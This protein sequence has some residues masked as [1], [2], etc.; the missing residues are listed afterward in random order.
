[1]NGKIV[2]DLCPVYAPFFGS[3]G[4]VAALVFCGMSTRDTL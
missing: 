4:A 3:M 2:S 1:M